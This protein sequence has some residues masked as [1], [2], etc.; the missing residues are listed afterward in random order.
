M[1]AIAAIVSSERADWAALW[2]AGPLHY[3]LGEN[4]FGRVIKLR[5]A[6]GQF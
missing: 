2:G 5:F 1:A 6:G 4:R 3:N